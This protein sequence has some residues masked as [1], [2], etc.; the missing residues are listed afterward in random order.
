MYL[1]RYLF[2]TN[3]IEK[4]WPSILL[5]LIMIFH[6]ITPGSIVLAEIDPGKKDMSILIGSIMQLTNDSLYYDL[7]NYSVN[8][9]KGIETALQSQPINDRKKIEFDVMNDSNDPITTV[10]TAREMIDKGILLMLGN[11]GSVST[12]KLMKVLQANQVP[13]MGFYTMGDIDAENMLGYRPNTAR[14]VIALIDN[15][16]TKNNARAT[17]VCIF[18]QNDVFGLA[19]ING[20]KA[21]LEKLSDTQATIN[22]LDHILDMMMGG[23]NPALN[24]IGPVGLYQYETVF[25]REAYLSLK[26]WER[27]SGNQCRFVILVAIPKVAADFIAYTHYRNESWSFGAVS[28]TAAGHALSRY[29]R[30]YGIEKNI[31][32][33]QVVPELNSSLPIVV[34]ARN[35]LGSDLNHISLEGYIVGRMFLT[36]LNSMKDPVTRANFIKAARQNTFDMGGL[37][38]DFTRGNTG[39]TLI[40][41]NHVN[42]GSYNLAKQ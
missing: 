22:K 31:V 1:P 14:E 41:L 11:V 26:N 6:T 5:S 24:S 3:F 35:A 36:I 13:A 16:V 18:A 23:I 32:I 2:N 7:N 40:I 20:L 34:D 33:T 9:K 27:E 12:L 37:K 4:R 38:I 15:Y 30:N 25:I 21:A 19:G 8:M 17:Q 39:S 42:L 29:I 28:I 10:Q